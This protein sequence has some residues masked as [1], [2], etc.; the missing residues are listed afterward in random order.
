[1]IRY[2][3]GS[4]DV[5]NQKNNY[6]DLFKVIGYFFNF[7]FHFVQLQVF[8]LDFF[9]ER[10][11]K[12]SY[13]YLFNFAYFYHWVQQIMEARSGQIFVVCWVFPTTKYH[14]E[15]IQFCFS[16]WIFH[17]VLLHRVSD[18]IIFKIVMIINYLHLRICP[19][20]SRSVDYIVS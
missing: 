8:L 7:Q 16:I 19:W 20:T 17:F 6:N 11:I 12:G 14:M 2:P 18:C 5:E 13:C 15:N 3:S 1:M 10:K 4:T 9:L